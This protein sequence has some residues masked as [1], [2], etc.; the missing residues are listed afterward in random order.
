MKTYDQ[1]TRTDAR[2][3]TISPKKSFIRMHP[4]ARG[5]RIIGAMPLANSHRFRYSGCLNAAR[6]VRESLLEEQ[7]NAQGNRRVVE[8]E[9]PMADLT[10]LELLARV[11][12]GDTA[13]FAQLYDLLAG[14]LFSIAVKILRDEHTAEDVVQEVFIQI[15]EKAGKYNAQLGKPTTWAVTMLRNKAI[16]RLRATQRG[17]RLIEAATGE[18]EVAG[19]IH[20]LP[21]AE[22]LGDETAQTV[23]LAVARL[24]PEQKQAIELAFFSGLTQTEIAE[25]LRTPLG[26]VKARIRRGMIE[27]RNTIEPEW[28][29]GS[30]RL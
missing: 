7:E 19:V 20:A 4:V 6:P 28:A 2:T 22:G 11:A 3:K 12:G 29:A 24:A 30:P 15:W 5:R 27:L 16:D 8:S 18:Q 21:P 25:V 17:Q 9:R 23:R 14:V 13:A 26:T 1:R 10:E